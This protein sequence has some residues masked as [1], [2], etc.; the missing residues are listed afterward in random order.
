MTEAMRIAAEQRQNRKLH[1]GP[2]FCVIKEK[3][4]VK[5]VND[6]IR[7]WIYTRVDAQNKDDIALELHET[8][9]RRYAQER[10]Y[11]VVGASVDAA[12]GNNL[13]RSGLNQMLEAA[14]HNSFDILLVKRYDRICRDTMQ[15]A[16]YL[17]QLQALGLEV[18]S[19]LE[20]SVKDYALFS[21]D[22]TAPEL[23]MR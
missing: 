10:G 15:T 22:A 12:S 18:F 1:G 8:E 21:L 2:H 4:E 16:V 19:L 20:G 3:Q 7:A 9:L 11:T 6:K 17:C 13:D 14:Q 5:I 23:T